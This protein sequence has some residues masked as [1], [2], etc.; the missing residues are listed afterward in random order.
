M[1]KKQDA[2]SPLYAEAA[3]PW[4]MPRFRNWIA[5]AK[6][7]ALVKDA[8]GD[9]LGPLGLKLPHYDALAAIFRFPG[10]TQQEL[11]DR[12][13]V[14]RSTLSM[15]L[16]ELEKQHLV[17]RKGDDGDKRLRRLF[18][19]SEGEAL[20]RRG[21]AAQTELIDDMMGALS[22]E[23]CERIGDMMRRVG[24]FMIERSRRKNLSEAPAITHG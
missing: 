24:Q 14:G 3:F 15:L 20:T 11:A 2:N 5:V 18:L 23:E 10:M 7:A 6:V 19:T 9:A 12:L 21:L 4:E 16:P 22:T 13:L 1:N 17:I 8:M